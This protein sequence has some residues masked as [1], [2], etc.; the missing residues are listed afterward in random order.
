MSLNQ[1]LFQESSSYQYLLS[2]N[3]PSLCFFVACLLLTN[4]VHSRGLEKSRGCVFET[5]KRHLVFEVCFEGG[6]ITKE[7]REGPRGLWC[8]FLL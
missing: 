2:Q 5:A 8:S 6:E 4:V 1:H 7:K 3:F